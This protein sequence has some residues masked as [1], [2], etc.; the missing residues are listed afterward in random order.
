MGKDL[1]LRQKKLW[2][3][4]WEEYRVWRSIFEITE[5]DE[6]LQLDRKV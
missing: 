1:L 2:N 3:L 4:D 6:I 5:P